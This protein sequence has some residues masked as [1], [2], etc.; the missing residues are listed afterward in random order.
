MKVKVKIIMHLL[1][2]IPALLAAEPPGDPPEPVEELIVSASRVRQARDEAT[3]GVEIID[4]ARIEASGART[5]DELLRSV[6]GLEVV[7]SRGGQSLRLRGLDSRHLAIWLDGQPLIGRVDGALDLRRIRLEDIERVEIAR[8]PGS[9]LYGTDALAGVIHLVRRRPGP[10]ARVEARARRESHN[11][12]DLGLM[13]SGHHRALSGRLAGRLFGT[14]GYDLDR[15]S[16]ATDGD[17]IEGGGASLGLEWRPPAPMDIG[18]SGEVQRRDARGVTESATGAAFDRRV[19]EETSSASLES[20]LRA[21]DRGALRLAARPSTWRQQY[22]SD[23]RGSDVQDSYADT[24]EV[25]LG[26]E[27]VG[28]LLAGRRRAHLVVLGLEGERGTMSSER[29]ETGRASRD[30]GAIWLQDDWTLARAPRVALA[31]GLRLDLDEQFGAHGSGRLAARFN[32][33]EVLDLRLSGGSAW[34]A[35][36]FKQLFL[37]FDHSGYGYIVEGNPALRP[38]TSLGLSAEASLRPMAALE[39]RVEAWHDELDG[40]IDIELVAEGGASEPARYRYANVGRARTSGATAQARLQL[41]GPWLEAGYTRT[42]AWDREAG[43]RLDGRPPDRFTGGAGLVH[44][45]WTLDGRWEHAGPR[46]F[47][48]SGQTDWSPAITWL[49][50][51]LAA[52]LSSSLSVEAGVRNLLDERE[53]VY[54]GL[55]PRSLYLGISAQAEPKRETRDENS[56]ADGGK[57]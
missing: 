54:L 43:V 20:N 55:S 35:P 37:F 5:L 2:A 48:V 36:D 12:G 19:L 10:G 21:E 56:P 45:P 34:R 22:L 33:G 32:P 14:G 52:E 23:Q 9:A 41:R 13:V 50:L 11:G 24:R 31:P 40:L 6:P 17:A 42:E 29:I 47:T 18:L 53:D 4:R 30:R 38:E 3:V 26:L 57:R 15:G 27:A 25:R 16:A 51:R 44:G 8:G 7:D 28:R 49:D 1:L 46:P 39:L